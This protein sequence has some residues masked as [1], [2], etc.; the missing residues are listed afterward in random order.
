M[1][2]TVYVKKLHP[3]AILPRYGSAYAAGADLCACLTQSCVIAPGQTVLVPTGL[4]MALPKGYGGFVFAR[5]G[6]GIRHGVVPG[7]C[8][9]VI[10]A[11]YRGEV[12]VGLHNHSDTAYTIQPGERIAQL[13][14][15]ETPMWEAKEVDSLDDTD[16]GTGGFGSTGSR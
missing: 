5:S 15:L 12:L 1:Q 16:R 10:D 8:V 6:L 7:N 14:V 13:V 11:D 9:G 2:Q 3:E 4:A